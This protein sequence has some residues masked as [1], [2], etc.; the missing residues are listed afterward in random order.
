V[1]GSTIEIKLVLG[2]W[3]RKGTTDEAGYW[4]GNDWMK[5]NSAL[6]ISCSAS[7][8]TWT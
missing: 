1:S 8:I 4:I 6:T 7:S 2:T 3:R 5:N